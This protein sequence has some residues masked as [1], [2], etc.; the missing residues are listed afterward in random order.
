MAIK[1]KVSIDKLADT[2][3]QEL[4]AFSQEVAEQ[5]DLSAEKVGKEALKKLKDTSPK[6]SGKYAKAW[7]MTTDPKLVKPDNRI[8]HVKA[9]H[10]RLTHLLEFGHVLRGGGRSRAFPHIE[11]A[12]DEVVKVFTAAVEEAIGRE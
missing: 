3:R 6:K 4:L 8:L 5:I 1:Q 2:I 12:E 11:K 9:P 7:T 10:Y